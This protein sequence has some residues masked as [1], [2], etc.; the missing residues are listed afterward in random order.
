MAPTRPG[1]MERKSES[2][3][4]D[5]SKKQKVFVC[6]VVLLAP[7]ACIISVLLVLL[8]CMKMLSRPNEAVADV[9][10]ALNCT[11]NSSLNNARC[12][13][14]NVGMNLTKLTMKNLS[15]LEF[16]IKCDLRTE[17]ASSRRD[18]SWKDCCFCLR[19]LTRLGSSQDSLA[20]KGS[21]LIQ[22]LSRK[23]K[24]EQFKPCEFVKMQEG[25]STCNNIRHNKETEKQK[26]M[27]SNTQI[28]D[29]IFL[30]LL[31]LGLVAFI[32]M[33]VYTEKTLKLCCNRC[34]GDE[35]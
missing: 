24:D 31:S 11:L 34:Y 22:E 14:T 29:I 1:K 4:K 19:N 3:N 5:F 9:C 27:K 30:V 32:L 28:V 20:E 2:E 7:V 23:A 16:R 25:V 21:R 12:S 15:C 13:A 8:V 18:C 10:P 35:I 26:R 6:R 17:E 33:C